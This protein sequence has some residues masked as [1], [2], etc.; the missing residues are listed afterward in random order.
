MICGGRSKNKIEQGARLT[1]ESALERRID[2]W[3]VAWMNVKQAICGLLPSGHGWHC[4]TIPTQSRL[5]RQDFGF[6]QRHLALECLDPHCVAETAFAETGGCAFGIWIR[7]M[8]KRR[9]DVLA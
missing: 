7:A 6:H 1:F 4:D 9:I 8:H 2:K 5:H 3:R